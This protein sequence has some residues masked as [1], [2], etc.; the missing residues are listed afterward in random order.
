MKEKIV[1]RLV[2]IKSIVTILLTLLFCIL[3]YQGV[4]DGDKVHAVFL[5]IV[6]FYFGTQH[7]KSITK[8]ET[9][10]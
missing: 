9:D 6:G 5:I 7:E 1:N 2:S 3:A 4:I 10:I 8:E